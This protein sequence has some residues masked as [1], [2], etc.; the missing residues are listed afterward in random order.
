MFIDNQATL[1]SV[2]LQVRTTTTFRSR[3][4][5]RQPDVGMQD[6][7]ARSG[8]LIRDI[9]PLKSSGSSAPEVKPTGTSAA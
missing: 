5:T 2:V 8:P 7:S 1:D 9:I 6:K 4:L 3:G